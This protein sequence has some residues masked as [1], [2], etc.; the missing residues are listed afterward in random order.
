MPQVAAREKSPT[1]RMYSSPGDA[2]PGSRKRSVLDRLED[3]KFGK[4]SPP[5]VFWSFVEQQQLAL[6]HSQENRGQ[7]LKQKKEMADSMRRWFRCSFIVHFLFLVHNSQFCNFSSW[8]VYGPWGDGR[9]DGSLPAK[10]KWGN[11]TCWSVP[12]YPT[13]GA[14]I[15]VVKE[16]FA[17]CLCVIQCKSAFKRL[18]LSLLLGAIVL[19]GMKYEL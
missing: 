5:K 4:S 6:N 16:C 19:I 13:T 10:E 9:E 11:H 8:Q 12:I 14:V 2:E 7:D 15:Y 17:I 18:C 3:S 1:L